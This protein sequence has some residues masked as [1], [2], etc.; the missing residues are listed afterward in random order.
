MPTLVLRL[1]CGG[2]NALKGMNLRG[3]LLLYIVVCLLPVGF[4]LTYVLI[5][6]TTVV[7]P[8][9][10][11]AVGNHISSYVRKRPTLQHTVQYRRALVGT[12]RLCPVRG[13]ALRRTVTRRLVRG[14]NETGIN[15]HTR[16]VIIR[17]LR[18]VLN[19]P[20]SGIRSLVAFRAVT[21]DRPIVIVPIAI[22]T[23]MISR[24][25]ISGIVRVR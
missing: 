1:P 13:T 2:V 4:T 7:S 22:T 10:L 14:M 15:L 6:V 23:M 16:A 25:V 20:A 12:V 5:C 17:T 19:V 18:C 24:R 21:G 11:F 8:S 9:Y 3:V